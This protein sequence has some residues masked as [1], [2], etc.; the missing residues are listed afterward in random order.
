MEGWKEELLAKPGSGTIEMFDREVPQDTVKELR[1]TS[2]GREVPPCFIDDGVLDR[3]A[4]RGVRELTSDS[5]AR[6]DSL[7]GGQG[8]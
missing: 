5:A 1:F 7:L 3:Q 4:M 2:G 6:L 8:R